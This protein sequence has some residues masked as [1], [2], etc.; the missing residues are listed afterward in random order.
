MKPAPFEMARPTSL[1]DALE[2]LASHPD[3]KVIA[4]GQSLGPAMNFRLATPSLVIDLAR[5]PG[6]DSIRYGDGMVRI[7]AATRQMDLLDSPVIAAH[8]PLLAR[9]VPW[10]GHVQTRSRGTIGGSLC[11]ADPSAELPLIMVALGAAFTIRRGTASR[12]V[13]AGDFFVGALTTCLAPDELL[14]EIAFPAA[15]PGAQIAFQ[16]LARRRGDFAI[17]AV[18][19]QLAGGQWRIAV[20]GLEAVPRLC[21]GLAA[22]LQ[23][24]DGLAAGIAAELAA[25]APLHDAQVGGPFRLQLARTLL[26]DCLAPLVTA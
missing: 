10:I 17:V 12:M 15:V 8:A 3:A 14:T 26:S 9:A 7:G 2:L 4:G 1:E 6:L 23:R 21:S 22:H 18:A 13:A 25:V 11:H 16:E 5:V 20:G 19:A 24:G